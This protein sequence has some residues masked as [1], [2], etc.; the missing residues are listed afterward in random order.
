MSNTSPGPSPLLPG[1]EGDEI[2]RWL[3]EWISAASQEYKALQRSINADTKQSDS[4]RI[5]Q[6]IN[7]RVK[8]ITTNQRRLISSILERSYRKITV[9]RLL[10]T[11]PHT[12]MMSLLTDPDEIAAKAPKQYKALLTKRLHC[13][14]NMSEE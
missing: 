8:M 10:V 4:N 1:G 9:D 3:N 6:N 14:D 12:K 2:T 5:Q 13:Y 11:D 7:E